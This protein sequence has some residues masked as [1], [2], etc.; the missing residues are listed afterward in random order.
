MKESQWLFVIC[1]AS[2]FARGV[3]QR[4]L[5]FPLACMERPGKSLLI[6]LQLLI[7]IMKMMMML[8]IIIIMIKLIRATRRRRKDP[9]ISVSDSNMFNGL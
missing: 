7:I 9:M 8:I 3:C 2:I 4:Y 5:P 6:I 1:F